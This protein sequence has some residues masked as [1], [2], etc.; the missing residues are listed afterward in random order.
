M[1]TWKLDNLLNS[2]KFDQKVKAIHLEF[3]K[4]YPKWAVNVFSL[5]FDTSSNSRKFDQMER[6]Y[7]RD[8]MQAPS[9]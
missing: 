8:F 7:I 9:K 5:K 2:S 1:F 4:K 6:L 3:H